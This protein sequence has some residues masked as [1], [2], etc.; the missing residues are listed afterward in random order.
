MQEVRC[1]GDGNTPA[2]EYTFFYG[3]WDENHKSG[4]CLF[5]PKKIVSVVKRAEFVNHRVF[6]N[7]PHKG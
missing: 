7:Y 2:E 4:T 5:V 6:L 3:K 1:D